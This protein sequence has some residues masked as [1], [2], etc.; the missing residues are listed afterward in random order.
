MQRFRRN[1]S[2]KQNRIWRKNIND[3][4]INSNYICNVRNHFKIITIILIIIL[5]VPVI[6]YA[7]ENV[8]E[9]QKD[10]LDI[11][12]FLNES[13]KYTQEAFPELEG[14][15]FLNDAISGKL[16]NN[17]IF[18]YIMNIFFKEITS[19]I[20][21]AASI[22]IIIIIHSVLHS[23]SDSFENK[24]VSQVSYYIQFI[25]IVTLVMANFSD[26]MKLMSNTIEDLV[27]FMYTLVP[28]VITLMLATGNIVSGGL[29][30]PVLLLLMQFIGNIIVNFI[31]PVVMI[32]TILRNNF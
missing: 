10:T 21:M 17:T 4:N 22:L 24:N 8:L 14:G 29:I 16:N 23:I 7:N 26:M 28:I 6:S 25:L 19:T 3:V 9:S 2:S 18:K 1:C 11:S 5:I 12:S 15:N 30:Q 32:G 20:K 13:K 27:G 31:I